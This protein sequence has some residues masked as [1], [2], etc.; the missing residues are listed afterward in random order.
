MTLQNLGAI[1][2]VQHRD[3]CDR[4][5]TGFICLAYDVAYGDIYLHLVQ[6]LDEPE[7]WGSYFYKNSR[8]SP[9][10]SCTAKPYWPPP[11]NWKLLWR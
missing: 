8:Q 4:L 1:G 3:Q 2:F 11:R 5:V 6:I 10:G 7:N 9:A